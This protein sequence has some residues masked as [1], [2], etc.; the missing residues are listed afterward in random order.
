MPQVAPSQTAQPHGFAGVR[1]LRDVLA[2]EADVPDPVGVLRNTYELLQRGAALDPEAPALSFFLRTEDQDRPFVWTHREWMARITQAANAF[3]Q[4]GVE[5]DDVIAFIL[6]NLPETHWTIWGGE[7]AGIVFAINPLLEPAL[8]T[9][10]M[11]AARPKVLVT[12]A[13]TPGADV[14]Q[15][16]SQAARGVAS[17]RHVLTVSPLAYLRHP[18]APVLRGLSRLK[19][20]RRL[21]QA[22][23][24]PLA[25]LL[26]AAPA[27]ALAF[28]PPS[29]DDRA[30]YFCTG[31]TTGLPKIAVRTHRTEVANALELAAAFGPEIEG[32][33]RTLFCGL[34][35]FHVNAQ[36]GTGLTPWSVGAHVVLGT[37]QG[38]RA[39]GLIPRFWD[40]AAHHRILFFSGVPT[41]YSALLQHPPKEQDLSQLK[42]GVCG[43]APM[44]VELF[45]RFQ[46]ETGVKILEGYG[47]TEG[48][49]V[50][51]INPPHGEVRLGSIGIRLPWQQMM[52]FVLDEQGRWQRD[53]ACDEVGVLGIR[54]PNLFEGYLH[55]SH[56]EGL[57]IERPDAHGEMQRWLNTGDLG[58]QD[59]QGYFWLTGRKKELIIRGG[60]NIDPKLIEEALHAHP[61]VALAAAVGRPDAHAGEVP[62]VYVQ[63]REGLAATEAALMQHAQAQVAERAA[64]PKHIYVVES[65][66]T[67]AIGKIF[68]PALTLRELESVVREEAEAV[69]AELANCEAVQD[70]RAGILVR[71]R[72]TG[73]GEELG[74]RLS[75]YT[76]KQ[77]RVD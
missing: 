47:L 21:A 54:G 62:V 19:T 33:G 26:D 64:W 50:S 3:R 58:R 70:P 67:T 23:V 9:E 61:A 17:L 1:Q 40:I 43:A 12:L 24:R 22:R 2:I 56:N 74:A 31:G 48:G 76:F 60:H 29:L 32:R 53:A 75:R 15:K 8:M 27:Q 7:A 45:H 57:W 46:Q 28:A 30:S 25:P 35:L 20:P 6:P 55:A 59:A 65:L 42:Y 77:E 71:W 51:S 5:R 4:L 18:L 73:K 16:A 36:I 10:L 63:L 41:V 38:Y 37:P 72:A 34:P 11:N 39:P 49:C 66:P 13:P 68:K 52:A 69:G 14:W 44:P